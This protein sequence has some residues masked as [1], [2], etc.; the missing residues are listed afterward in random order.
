MNWVV[1]VARRACASSST[2]A[3]SPPIESILIPEVCNRLINCLCWDIILFAFYLAGLAM[4]ATKNLGTFGSGTCNVCAQILKNKILSIHDWLLIILRLI[5]QLTLPH[6]W[7]SSFISFTKLSHYSEFL[8]AILPPLLPTRHPL[9][10]QRVLT[11]TVCLETPTLVPNNKD[12]KGTKQLSQSWQVW[13]HLQVESQS[14]H[15]SY[16]DFGKVTSNPH[17]K[18]LVHVME[19]TY[20]CHPFLGRSVKEVIFTTCVFVEAWNTR[21]TRNQKEQDKLSR[22]FLVWNLLFPTSCWFGAV[23]YQNLSLNMQR[24]VFKGIANPTYGI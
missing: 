20:M 23:Q 5:H 15:K 7:S 12:L 9:W 6:S 17:A 13:A 16:I 1:S 2:G 11:K 3:S 10:W 24:G 19:V 21:N 18:D 22:I 14:L 4:R 8:N